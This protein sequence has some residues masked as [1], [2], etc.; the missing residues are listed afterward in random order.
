MNECPRLKR[1]AAL[2]MVE[3]AVLNFTDFLLYALLI[4]VLFYIIPRRIA[5]WYHKGKEKQ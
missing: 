3:A 2:V 1:Q 4:A 5:H